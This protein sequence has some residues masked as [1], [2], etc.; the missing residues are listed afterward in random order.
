MLT[1]F[2]FVFVVRPILRGFGE[3]GMADVAEEEGREAKEKRSE[4]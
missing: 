2:E 4:L 3:R 1:P